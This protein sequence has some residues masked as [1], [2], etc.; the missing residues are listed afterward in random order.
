MKKSK[1]EK[2]EK[3]GWKVGSSAEFLSLTPEEEIYIELKVTLSQYLHSKRIKKH[4]TQEQLAEK[5]KSSQS[6]I[7]KMEKGDP[8]VSIDLLI[9]SLLA[10]GTT[11][12][13]LAKVIA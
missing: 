13:E 4:L 8:T 9:K 7:A 6:R 11:K 10:I 5:I 2:L 12:D 1:K 3:H